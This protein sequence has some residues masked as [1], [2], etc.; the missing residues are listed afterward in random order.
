MVLVR[1]GV[2]MPKSA[3]ILLLLL[4][5]STALANNKV[6]LPPEIMS[7]K[8]VAIIARLGPVG[9]GGYAPDLQ[10]AKEQLTEALQKW[11]KYVIVADPL[12]ADIVLRITE[13]HFGSYGNI[14]IYNSGD[15]QHG[16]V[17]QVP[18]LGDILEVYK[19]GGVPDEKSTALWT[20]I[21]TGGFSW[22]AKR[23]IAKF[24]KY[25]EAGK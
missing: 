2:H 12:K 17:Q 4:A 13:G 10:R 19:G 11:K 16:T 20:H 9:S 18:V 23:A 15:Y 21:E 8:T 6:D 7:A 25:V 3:R 5:I 14:N 24:K 22:P 1:T